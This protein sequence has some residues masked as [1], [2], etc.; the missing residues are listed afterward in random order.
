[1][2]M[3]RDC[4]CTYMHYYIKHTVWLAS[5]LYV[6]RTI[7]LTSV[8]TMPRRGIRPC[9]IP[10]ETCRRRRPDERRGRLIIG[11][12]IISYVYSYY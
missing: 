10:R 4:T 7:P 6:T 5:M 2:M 11:I 1:M 12:L 3:T 8:I 9:V